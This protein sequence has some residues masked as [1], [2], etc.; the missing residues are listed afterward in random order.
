MTYPM[1]YSMTFKYICDIQGLQSRSAD[2]R[3]RGGRYKLS[4]ESTKSE[5]RLNR[6]KIGFRQ[7]EGG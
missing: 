1:T 5:S 4:V 3:E 6:D 2:R 7:R